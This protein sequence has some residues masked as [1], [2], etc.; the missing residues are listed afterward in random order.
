M[1]YKR[2][3]K[4]IECG[5]IYRIYDLREP[6]DT[7][8]VGSTLGPV[9]FRYANHMMH[10]RV[11][12]YKGRNHAMYDYMLQE[13][14]DNFHWELL[15][16]LD[17]T[18][19][20]LMHQAEQEY[21]DRSKPRFNRNHAF[22]TEVEYSRLITCG[23]GTVVVRYNLLRHTKTKKHQAYERTQNISADSGVHSATG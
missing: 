20:A 16:Q 1:V 18:T 22:L 13:D 7:L 23:C 6:S 12:N 3:H 10:A 21:L 9:C 2:K 5:R 17:N 4:D 8:Y 19:R 11:K 15:H 14:P